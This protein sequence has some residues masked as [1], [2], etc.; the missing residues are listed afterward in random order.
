MKTS[1]IN[2]LAA[3][4]LL[5][6]VSCTQNQ[7]NHALGGAALGGLAGAVLG[8]DSRDIIKGAALGAAAGAGTA[9]YN[10]NQNRNAGAYNTGG[11]YNPIPLTEPQYK[12]AQPTGQAGI[13]RSPYP[14]YGKVNVSGFQSGQLAKVP[15]TNTI[16][17]VP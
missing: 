3:G 12:T 13:V 2:F 15:G 7:Q 1:L 5:T 14:P 16:F 4:V 10:E 8:D 6:G 11:D 9:A 17:K